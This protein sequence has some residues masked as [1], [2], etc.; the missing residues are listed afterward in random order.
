MTDDRQEKTYPR[1]SERNK[2]VL[3]GGLV[4]L[5]LT[6]VAGALSLGVASVG[7]PEVLSVLASA[8]ASAP[9]V[10]EGVETVIFDLRLPRVLMAILCGAALASSGAAVQGILRNP[11]VSPYILGVAAGAAFGAALAMVLG[12]GFTGLGR[13][14]VVANAFL[15]ATV[16]IFLVYGI[17]SLR[18]ASAETIILAGIVMGYIFSA[19]VAVLQYVAQ[20]HELRSIVFWMMGSLWG[21]EKDSL[22]IVALAA[23]GGLFIL[24]RYAWD[25]NAFGAGEE[26]ARSLGVRVRRVRFLI[27]T[28]SALMT[29]TVVAFVGV[30]GFVCLMSPHIARVLVGADHRTLLPVSALVG[31]I[32]L[33][34]ADTGARTLVRPMEIPVGIM[35][36]L[37]GGPF[38]IYLLFKRRKDWWS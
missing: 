22:A 9:H 12:V 1:S 3:I 18:R 23:F 6:L 30:I 25:L 35:T 32:L 21:A 15:I 11:L 4:T 36:S 24:T 5:L 8:L 27:L 17:A 34:A 28:V 2:I 37:I 13:Y 26:V 38:F 14:F 7:L 20:G 16:T 29:A 10:S 31:A 19:L 33:L